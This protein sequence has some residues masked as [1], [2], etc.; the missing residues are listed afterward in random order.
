MLERIPLGWD[1]EMGN[2]IGIAV[3]SYAGWISWNC[4][5]DETD[6]ND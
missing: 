6:S 3:N 4:G 5:E 2:N 1:E